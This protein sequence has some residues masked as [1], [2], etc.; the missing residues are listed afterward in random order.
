MLLSMFLACANHAQFP[1][2]SRGQTLRSGGRSETRVTESREIIHCLTAVELNCLGDWP[3]AVEKFNTLRVGLRHD[4]KTYAGQDVTIVVVLESATRGDVFELTQERRRHGRKF[5]LENNGSFKLRHNEFSW[6]NEIF[7]GIWTHEY[8]EKNI[9]RIMRGPKVW[10]DVK[11]AQKAMPE[12][13][14]TWYGTEE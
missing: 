10:V 3:P 5:N 8:M 1:H 12:V 9:K 6:P 11:T 4:Y 14:C 7:G 2:S 13:S